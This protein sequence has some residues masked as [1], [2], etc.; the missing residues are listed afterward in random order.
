LPLKPWL[1]CASILQQT[2]P[3]ARYADFQ[4][5]YVSVATPAQLSIAQIERF[6]RPAADTALAVRGKVTVLLFANLERRIGMERTR[7]LLYQITTILAALFLVGIMLEIVRFV[8]RRDREELHR[9]QEESARLYAELAREH[10]EKALALTEAQFRAVF[11]GAAIGI[12]ILDRSGGV[13]DANSVF[14]DHFGRDGGEFL[15]GHLDELQSVL[16]GKRK[17]FEFEQHYSPAGGNEL[18]IDATI[19]VV[20]GEKD[21]PQFAMCMFR[22]I[23]EVKRNE[24]RMVHDMTH[25]TLTGLPNRLL[26]ETKLRD[27]FAESSTLLDS[28]FAVLFVDLDHFKDFNE[29][30]GHGVGDM[31]LQSVATRLRASLD[32]N[33]L[34]ARLGSDEFAVL[35]RSLGDILHVESVARRIINNVCKPIQIGDRAIFAACSIGIAIGSAT[36]E[37]AEV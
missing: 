33:D 18:W 30:L 4:E 25:D 5:Q 21:L 34:V 7:R 26:F 9:V 12:A 3:W 1:H 16:T 24:R 2:T 35:I 14:R 13:V 37:R 29:S 15:A 8:A 20:S 36:Y 17:L 32:P 23:T 19:S 31:V 27:R 10:A 28:F 22:D 6:R 11:D